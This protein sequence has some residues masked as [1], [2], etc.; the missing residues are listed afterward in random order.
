MWSKYVYL[1][2]LNKAKYIISSDLQ[3]KLFK[4]QEGI[5]F[6][7]DFSPSNDN[8]KIKKNPIGIN[9]I[10]FKIL[11]KSNKSLVYNY[12]YYRPDFIESLI[13]YLVIRNHYIKRRNTERAR[14]LLWAGNVFCIIR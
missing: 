8:L 10:N 11:N 5:Y 3:V 2:C 7:D 13:V 9:I 4:A 6:P 14:K 12:V 1:N